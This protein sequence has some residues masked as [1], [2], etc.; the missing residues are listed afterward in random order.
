MPSE[1]LFSKIFANDIRWTIHETKVN[2]SQELSDDPIR[3]KLG[4][5]EQRDNR[6]K[7]R[8]SRDSL[9]FQQEM[10]QHVDEH[11]EPEQREGKTDETRQSQRQH[12]E[13]CHHVQRVRNQLPQVV[14]RGAIRTW[15][16]LDDD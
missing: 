5:S 9:I 14:L 12:A 1:D 10:S 3:K 16:V 4:T 15:V 13:S 2:A 11:A 8:K 7:K 6:S